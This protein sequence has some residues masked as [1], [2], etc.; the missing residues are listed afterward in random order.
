MLLLPFVLSISAFVTFTIAAC[1]STECKVSFCSDD[2]PSFL[3][4]GVPDK[5]LSGALCMGSERLYSASTGEAMVNGL[6]ISELSIESQSFSSSF[7]KA[8]SKEKGKVAL[9]HETPQGGQLAYLESLDNVCIELPIAQYSTSSG[10]GTACVSFQ[11]VTQPDSTI[12]PTI[13]PMVTPGI[14]M[15]TPV[16]SLE[17]SPTA[18]ETQGVLPSP[19]SF[20]G[21]DF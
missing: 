14:P 5:P 3:P 20:T 15:I 10:K 19:D 13:T 12:L 4:V 16:P 7:I 6:P 18:T 1:P 21:L 9:G 17:P 8:Y 2:S 11:L